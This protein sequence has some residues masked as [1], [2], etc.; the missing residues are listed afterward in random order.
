[1]QTDWAVLSLSGDPYAGG[2]NTAS[3]VEQ[4][5]QGSAVL[6]LVVCHLCAPR[7]TC[8]PSGYALTL[9]VVIPSPSCILLKQHRGTPCSVSYSRCLCGKG[10]FYRCVCGAM[11]SLGTL[12]APSWAQP[13]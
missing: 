9:L 8:R 12:V 10:Y 13:P 2:T 4:L 6:A 7:E 3:E 11:H 5:G 1:M